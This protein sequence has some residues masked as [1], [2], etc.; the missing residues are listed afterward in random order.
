MVSKGIEPER[1]WL[2]HP[3]AP[4]FCRGSESQSQHR[5]TPRASSPRPADSNGRQERLM[6]GPHSRRT[7]QR[8]HFVRPG[9]KASANAA[10]TPAT[11]PGQAAERRINH[12]TTAAHSRSRRRLCGRVPFTRR[13]NCQTWPVAAL[14]RRGGRAGRFNAATHGQASRA[15]FDAHPAARRISR[16][17]GAQPAGPRAPA[18]LKSAGKDST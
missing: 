2:A 10:R 18:N 13:T 17:A 4:R 14:H 5:S 8:P 6:S 11:H 16:R 3:R 1:P 12:G 15:T 7:S 9:R